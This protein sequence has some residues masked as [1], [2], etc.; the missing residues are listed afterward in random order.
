MEDI[1]IS[2]EKSDLIIRIRNILHVEYVAIIRYFWGILYL[3]KEMW[4]PF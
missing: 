1:K 4:L 3:A 2:Y